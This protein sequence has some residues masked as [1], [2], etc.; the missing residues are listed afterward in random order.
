MS[1]W[2]I[3]PVKALHESKS[4][5]RDVLTPDQRVDLSM[6]M[7]LNTLRVLAE[8][9]EIERTLV[10]SADPTVLALAQEHGAKALEEHGSPSLNKALTRATDLL[11]DMKAEVVLVLPADL[12]LL[13]ANDVGALIQASQAPP[14]VVA[15]D[16]QA[17]VVRAQNPPIVGEGDAQAPID[18]AQAPPIVVI[19]PDQRRSGTNALVMAPPGTIEYGFGPDSFERHI[20][21]AEAAGARVEIIELPTLGLDLDAPE[22]LEIYHDRVALIKE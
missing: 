17:S 19:S 5:L 12:P 16:V 7:L 8:F 1:L 21:S 9:P 4:R 14:I 3:V 2:A 18:P 20:R 22:D 13:Q 15:K 6:E 11:R 10:V